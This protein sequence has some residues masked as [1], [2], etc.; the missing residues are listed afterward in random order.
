MSLVYLCY[1]D[2]SCRHSQ[3]DVGG[4]GLVLKS[5]RGEIVEKFGGIRK[6]TS[7]AM[8]LTAILEALS[9]LPAGASAIIFSDSVSAIDLCTKQ[10]AIWKKS[11]WRNCGLVADEMQL[12]QRVDHLLAEKALKLEW[13]WIRAHNGN[14]GNERADALAK[15]GLREVARET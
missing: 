5:P 10:I 14:A 8:E 7:C 12:L 4:W 9:L 3:Q 13:K 11:E 6:T 15:Q 2:G 1:T